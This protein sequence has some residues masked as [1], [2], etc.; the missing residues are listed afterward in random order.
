MSKR[1]AIYIRV[2]SDLQTVENQLADLTIA[3]ERFGWNVVGIY[4]D[5]A[6]SGAKGREKRPGFDALL[7]AVT[8]GEVQMV[9]AWSVCRLG[10]SLRDLVIFLEEL[11]EKGVDLYLHKQSLDTSTPTGRAMFG[12]LS[13]FSEMER[14][15]LSERVKASLNRLRAEGK[16]LG[17][18]TTNPAKID[19]VKLL[20]TGGAGI[21]ETARQCKVST[22]LVQK[23]KKELA[24]NGE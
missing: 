24:A 16:K 21:R 18:P 9:S 8:R 20:L 1:V 23:L 3:A 4:R 11:R 17:R 15:I 5:E 2:S 22:G 12:M 6:I 10:R 14:S 13:I 7:K 19:R